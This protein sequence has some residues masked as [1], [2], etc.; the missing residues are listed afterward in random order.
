[1]KRR[2]TQRK[3]RRQT[4]YKHTRRTKRMRGGDNL[5]NTPL[6]T[7]VC[8]IFSTQQ[9]LGAM[10]TDPV[11]RKKGTPDYSI[12][13]NVYMELKRIFADHVTDNTQLILKIGSNDTTR[14][15]AVSG[16]NPEKYFLEQNVRFEMKA[17]NNNEKNSEAD[18]EL[19]VNIAISP[20]DSYP[21]FMHPFDSQEPADKNP[22]PPDLKMYQN[23]GKKF[24][25]AGKFPIVP[26]GN[27]QVQEIINLI[28][29]HRGPLFL[30]NAMGGWCYNIFKYII[31]MRTAPTGYGGLV[32]SK[33]TAMC[34]PSIKLY[35]EAEQTCD[36]LESEKAYLLFQSE[37]PMVEK[38]LKSIAQFKFKTNTKY[39]NLS[40]KDAYN[41]LKKYR[42]LGLLKPETREKLIEL[43]GE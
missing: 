29:N 10:P 15:G 36:K 8:K 43:Y 26:E 3:S 25:I 27:A 38:L 40:S 19:T 18:P 28:V 34:N 12:D 7:K 41:G 32:D 24:Y 23:R 13:E 17:N 9:T 37:S 2:Q 4:R 33:S 39:S 42:Q 30:F 6:K 35:P 11:P 1:M 14:A 20:I 5:N 21:Y 16:K 31:D 22:A